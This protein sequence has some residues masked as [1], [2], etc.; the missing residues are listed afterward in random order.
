MFKNVHISYTNCW[1]PNKT[2]KIRIKL[3]IEPNCWVERLLAEFIFGVAISE[4]QS[5]ISRCSWQSSFSTLAWVCVCVCVSCFLC[6]LLRQYSTH[7]AFPIPI[8]FFF[9]A[10]CCFSTVQKKNCFVS[11]A[12]ISLF[13][14]ACNFFSRSHNSFRFKHLFL[15]LVENFILIFPKF[16]RFDWCVIRQRKNQRG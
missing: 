15:T 8:Q 5:F 7:S 13:R 11:L 16:A 6:L 14:R 12:F 10:F 4:K 1:I 9:S 2:K 3:W